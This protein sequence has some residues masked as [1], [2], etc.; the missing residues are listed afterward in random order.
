MMATV[1]RST[2]LSLR[3]ELAPRFAKTRG[4][5]VAGTLANPF[6]KQAVIDLLTSLVT[7]PT[8]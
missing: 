8:A 5:W 2:S 6:R 7:G 1:F 3:L 4:L